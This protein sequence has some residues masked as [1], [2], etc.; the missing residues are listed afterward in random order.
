M[1]LITFAFPV[2]QFTKKF[3]LICSWQSHAPYQLFHFRKAC[4]KLG[5][6][7]LTEDAMGP[8]IPYSSNNIC[9]S[10]DSHVKC[11]NPTKQQQHS[12]CITVIIKGSELAHVV[13]NTQPGKVHMGCHSTIK[14]K[15]IESSTRK[16]GMNIISIDVFILQK[17]SR[18]PPLQTTRCA[19][20]MNI[21]AGLE[22]VLFSVD[23]LFHKWTYPW[24]KDLVEC[25]SSHKPSLLIVSHTKVA[26]PDG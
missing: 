18:W 9:S 17:L 6:I 11:W 13:F 23:T 14:Q 19:L 8:V 7:P 21:V 4:Q 22:I 16:P 3:C 1:W 25:Y 24:C 10:L 26:R 20:P 15:I 5:L 12:R 2:F